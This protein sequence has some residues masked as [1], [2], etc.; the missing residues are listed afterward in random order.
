MNTTTGITANSIPVAEIMDPERISIS[1][2]VSVAMV[3]YNHERWIA[4]SIE[5]VLMQK[6]DFPIELVIA[7]DCSTD[8]TRSIVLAYQRQ[9]PNVI[10]LL[11]PERNLGVQDNLQ[12]LLAQ[13]RGTYI[14]FCEGDDYWTDPAKLRKQV[15]LL[16]QNPECNL[17]VARCNMLIESD[18]RESRLLTRSEFGPTRKLSFEEVCLAYYHTSTYVF[19]KS[20]LTKALQWWPDM[21]CFDAV[22]LM[23]LTGDSRSILLDDVVSVY[24]ITG[25]GMFSQLSKDQIVFK[26]IKIAE[27]CYKYFPK[28]W[29]LHLGK[30]MS[31]MYWTAC[32]IDFRQRQYSLLL[33]HFLRLL[34][35]VAK[36]RILSSSGRSGLLKW[37]WLRLTGSFK[38]RMRD[39]SAPSDL[40]WALRYAGL[41]FKPQYKI[42]LLMFGFLAR[43]RRRPARLLRRWRETHRPVMCVFPKRVA[44][45]GVWASP[46]ELGH[47]IIFEEIFFNNAYPLEKVPFTPDRILDC[48]AHIGLFSILALQR[49]PG[50]R[51]TAFEP[52]PENFVFLKRQFSIE[53]DVPDLRSEA[54]S[55]RAGI[56]R[57]SGYS[58]CDGRLE[59]TGTDDR[60]YE[61]QVLDLPAFVFQDAS[62][63]LLLKVDIEGEELNLFPS[64]IPMLPPTCAMFFETHFGEERWEIAK[65]LLEY[66]GFQVEKLNSRD[67]CAD[68]FALRT[69]NCSTT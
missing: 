36:H 6:T 62:S 19:L 53:S 35:L 1:P 31:S 22:Y 51:L 50:T 29:K 15:N 42:R 5:G 65:N 67:G 56:A 10:R 55:N 23:V 66:A 14:A 2:V 45:R 13:C 3:T 26:N 46:F 4:E 68:G 16:N 11:L 59:G 52:N 58:G 18:S 25:K 57:F 38:L 32:C 43:G 9:H 12:Y 47:R 27:S 40:A 21:P 64:L 49:F 48:G 41:G 54:V 63:R 37:L 17:C 7:E 33:S 39:K 34:P 69:A 20:S 61:V 8:T 28:R 24:R 44:G 60:S 30:A